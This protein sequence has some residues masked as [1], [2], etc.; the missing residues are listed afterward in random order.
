[1]SPRRSS[2]TIFCPYFVAMTRAPHFQF[3]DYDIV[4]FINKLK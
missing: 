1:M 4:D 2:D 3:V